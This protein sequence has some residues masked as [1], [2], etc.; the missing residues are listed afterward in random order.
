[1]PLFAGNRNEGPKQG[2]ADALAPPRSEHGQTANAGGGIHTPRTHGTLAR[3]LRQDMTAPGI[4]SVPLELRRDALF[5]DEDPAPYGLDRR[6][7]GGQPGL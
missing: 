3:H 4:P 5:L 1:M 2:R 6:Q 7:I